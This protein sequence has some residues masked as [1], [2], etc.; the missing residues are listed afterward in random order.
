M[1]Y[2]LDVSD[3][4]VIEVLI[5]VLKQKK[6][7]QLIDGKNYKIP[8]K[9]TLL[10]SSMKR[11]LKKTIM[12]YEDLLNG[13]TKYIGQLYNVLILLVNL[14]KKIRFRLLK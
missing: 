13:E 7:G 1:L 2:F 9:V 6:I 12:E 14:L 3:G 5:K 11:M 8:L 10:L 4:E